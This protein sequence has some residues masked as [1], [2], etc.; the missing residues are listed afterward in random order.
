MRNI[1]RKVCGARDVCPTIVAEAYRIETAGEKRGDGGELSREK[2]GWH[3][4][5]R[6][7]ESWIII[8]ITLQSLLLLGLVFNSNDGCPLFL[9]S[10]RPTG[11]SSFVLGAADFHLFSQMFL[12]GLLG[13]GLQD[14]EEKF[15]YP[16]LC[17]RQRST[18]LV[19][20]VHEHTLV[21][22]DVTLC[23]HVQSMV[24]ALREADN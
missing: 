10:G 2:S 7:E 9:H 19:N 4:A 8:A 18:Y 14:S 11:T 3:E 15:S 24:P 23:L 22:E 12:T 5:S 21:L 20:V 1:L 17:R 13:L 16:R 6:F